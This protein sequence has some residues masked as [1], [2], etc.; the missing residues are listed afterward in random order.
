MLEFFCA[1]GLVANFKLYPKLVPHTESLIPIQPHAILASWQKPVN[2]YQ[3]FL[4][5]IYLLCLQL[6]RTWGLIFH[7][8]GPKLIYL[9]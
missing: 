3:I 9:G 6:F 7:I 5:Y 1:P 2:H 4:T 8:T